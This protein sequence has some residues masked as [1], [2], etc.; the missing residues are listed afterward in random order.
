MSKPILA[1]KL[2]LPIDTPVVFMGPDTRQSLEELAHGFKE[3]EDWKQFVHETMSGEIYPSP[4]GFIEFSWD[5]KFAVYWELLEDHSTDRRG[6]VLHVFDAG[7]N[8]RALLIGSCAFDLNNEEV[9]LASQEN[10]ETVAKAWGV[11]ALDM[12][13]HHHHG[14]I[15]ALLSWHLMA[16]KETTSNPRSYLTSKAK[17]RKKNLERVVY[18]TVDLNLGPEI[19]PGYSKDEGVA[20]NKRRRHWVRTH[21]RKYPNKPLSKVKGHWRGCLKAGVSH[22]D[23]KVSA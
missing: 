17:G 4:F 20:F 16:H 23:Y 10:L 12:P 5:Q 19:I 22:H 14:F 6:V 21:F 2:P 13:E 11:S 1:P 15:C 7:S 9:V 3:P 8:R 18:R